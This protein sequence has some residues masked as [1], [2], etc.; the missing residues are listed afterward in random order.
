MAAAV[1]HAA[2]RC[3]GLPRTLRG[4]GPDGCGRVQSR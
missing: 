4:G 1:A 3:N 2:C